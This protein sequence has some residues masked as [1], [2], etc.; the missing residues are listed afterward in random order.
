MTNE[1][2]VFNYILSFTVYDS[3]FCKGGLCLYAWAIPKIVLAP[4]ITAMQV[5]NYTNPT[6][7]LLAELTIC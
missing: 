1:T 2:A 4:L 6:P 7:A 3:Q 5:L